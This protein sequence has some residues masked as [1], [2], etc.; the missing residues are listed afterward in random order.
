MNGFTIVGLRGARQEKGCGAE[1]KNNQGIVNINKK[2]ASEVA[3]G[4]H[5]KRASLDVR[6]AD[7]QIQGIVIGVVRSY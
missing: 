2:L 6:P 5:D 1:S 3:R 7:L 4:W